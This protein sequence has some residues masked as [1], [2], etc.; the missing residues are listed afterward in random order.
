MN[1]T[2][3]KPKNLLLEVTNYCNENCLFCANRKSTRDK[4]YIDES[5]VKRILN[6]AFDLGVR[7]VGFYTTGEPLLN[8]ELDKY[9]L[10]AKN[11][12]YTYTYLTTNGLFATKDKMEKLINSGL[13]SIKFSINAFN[14][15]EYKF[16][17]GVDKFDIVV[18]NLKNLY[19]Y[20]KENNLKF[21][22]FVSYIVTRYNSDNL[23]EV[24]E[25]FINYCDDIVFINV[26]NQSGM[27]P[28]NVELLSYNNKDN[29]II[30][31]KQNLPCHYPFNTI[32]ISKEGYL[33]ACCT[34][35]NNYLAIADLNKA[36]LKDA[37]NCEKFRLFRQKHINK[38]VL[39]TLCD[40]CI[41]NKKTLPNPL[42]DSLYTPMNEEVFNNY[43]EVT[44]R[45]A[46]YKQRGN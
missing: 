2:V 35:F 22:L 1:S 32:S 34:D 40:N 44:R 43:K 6:E 41:N 18:N 13:D 8:N 3:I 27:M 9:I 25:Y 21:K 17:H 16:I 5:F 38:N 46:Q 26:K 19:N 15:E 10:E 33:T 24:K 36:H 20:R 28:E 12:G 23:N 45:I 42:D 39:G 11:I 37:W 4:G 31:G 7:E 14:S 30:D 29:G